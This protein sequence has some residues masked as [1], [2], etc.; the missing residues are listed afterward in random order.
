MAKFSISMTMDD[1]TTIW[2][3]EKDGV[4]EPQIQRLLDW[5]WETHGARD[6]NGDLK[7]RTAPRQQRAFNKYARAMWQGTRNNTVRHEVTTA[8]KTARDAIPEFV[9][10]DDVEEP[11]V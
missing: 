3:W 11:E 6:E 7:G 4:A 10:P 5:I 1:G 9:E 2:G 8:V